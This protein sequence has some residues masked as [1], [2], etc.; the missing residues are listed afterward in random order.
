[1]NILFVCLGNICRSPVAAG[2]MRHIYEER[3]VTG[4]I[5]SAGTA[6]WNTGSPADC[7]SVKV[8]MESRIN[9]RNHRA[10][11][12]E[13][14]DF[15]KFDLIVVMDESNH[16]A[17]SMLA[18]EGMRRKVRRLLEYSHEPSRDVPDPYHGDES[19]FQS[20][21]NVIYG[22]C[23]ALAEELFGAGHPSPD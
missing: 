16:R 14:D 18:P 15:N 19:H 12:I 10:R 21:F 3:G 6:D 2:I 4:V 1:M 11:Q 13:P 5:E 20:M 9:L 23:L 8:A 22:G 7:R 17:V